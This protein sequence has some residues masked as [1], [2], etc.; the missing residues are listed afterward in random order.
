LRQDI[1][2]K[3]FLKRER[4]AAASRLRALYGQAGITG[5]TKKDSRDSKGRK[6]RHGE[7]P[8]ELAEYA[9]ILEEQLDLFEKRLEEAEEKVNEKAWMYCL[10]RTCRFSDKHIRWFKAQA[11]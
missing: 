10:S 6:A 9:D 7:L 1:P 5:V 11:A 2:V 8:P 3:E 4:V